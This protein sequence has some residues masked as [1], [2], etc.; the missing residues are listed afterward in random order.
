MHHFTCLGHKS[1]QKHNGGILRHDLIRKHLLAS[2]T[3]LHGH[4]TGCPLNLKPV[5]IC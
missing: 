5:F 1:L 2:G 3:W 4:I